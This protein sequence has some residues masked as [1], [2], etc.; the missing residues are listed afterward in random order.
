MVANLASKYDFSNIC[1]SQDLT[2]LGFEGKLELKK[3][4]KFEITNPVSGCCQSE[5]CLQFRSD[6]NFQNM[7]FFVSCQKFEAP[8]VR[9]TLVF[10]KSTEKSYLFQTT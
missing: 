2:F 4:I 3:L 6:E 7:W 5:T 10:I 8:K 9:Y 1:S